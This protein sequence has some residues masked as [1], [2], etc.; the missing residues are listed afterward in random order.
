MVCQIDRMDNSPAYSC[1]LTRQYKSKLCE[2]VSESV[3]YASEG[4]VHREVFVDRICIGDNMPVLVLVVC[5][6]LVY[7]PRQSLGSDAAFWMYLTHSR[8]HDLNRLMISRIAE[9]TARR[10]LALVADVQ[11][12]HCVVSK[13]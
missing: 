11:D 5:I 13:L 8:I 6:S 12:S 3:R 4:H 1:L 9:R 10:R 7:C 2:R